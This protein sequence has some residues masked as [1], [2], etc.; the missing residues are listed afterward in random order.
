[1]DYIKPYVGFL[2][3]FL[4]SR[5][6]LKVIFDSS[7]GTTGHILQQLT[8]NN[9]QLTTVLIN[10]KPDGNFPAHGPNPLLKGAT[11]QLQKE[12]KKQK[13]DLGV[14]F[15][16][17]GDRVFFVDNRGQWIDA[18]EIGYILM[19]NFKPPYVVGAVSS[20]RLKKCQ[21][22]NVKCQMYIS[23]TG[24]YFFKKLMRERKANL[25]VEHSGHYYFKDFFYCDAGIFAAISVINFVSRLK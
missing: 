4:R 21:M 17:D 16:G 24:H 10:A 23:R 2:K 12:I 20:W 14:I 11:A 9:R 6:K 8:T 18:N 5:R 1:M 15:D 19:Q 3:K 22:S 25:G 13:A 7:N